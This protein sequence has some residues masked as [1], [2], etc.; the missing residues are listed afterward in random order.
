MV[1]LQDLY[2]EVIIDHNRRPR[3]Y[4]KIEHADHVLEGF[5]PLCGDRITLYVKINLE[6]DVIDDVSFLGSGCAIS[7]ASASIMTECVKGLTIQQAKVV[8]K[9]FHLMLTTL[10]TDRPDNFPPKL[11]VFAGVREFPAR[12]KCATL[13]WHTLNSALCNQTEL[14]TTE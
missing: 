7:T 6:E 12:V 14:V 3:N 5:N 10:T 9:M 1:D 4:R 8:F 11:E 2:Q 13:A